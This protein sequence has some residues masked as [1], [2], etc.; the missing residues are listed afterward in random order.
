[1]SASL[2]ESFWFKARGRGEATFVAKRSESDHDRYVVTRPGMPDSQTTVGIMTIVPDGTRKRDGSGFKQGVMLGKSRR[3]GEA[4]WKPMKQID[5]PNVESVSAKRG[6]DS[7]RRPVVK[8]TFRQ[9][10]RSTRVVVMPKS[11]SLQLYAQLHEM[12]RPKYE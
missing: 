5:D 6:V 2:P 12:Y 10:T 4:F 3:L 8:L 11:I 1:M 9:N 7:E